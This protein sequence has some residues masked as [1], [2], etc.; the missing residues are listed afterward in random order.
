MKLSE[1][2]IGETFW[3]SGKH[4]RCT[5]IGTRIVAAI[6]IDQVQIFQYECPFCDGKSTS[7]VNTLSGAD[8]ERSGWFTGPP[9]IV[10]EHLFDEND[11]PACGLNP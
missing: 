11:L 6:R 1:F 4:Y 9:Y 5:D 10:V 3:C 2:K 7:H 8:A